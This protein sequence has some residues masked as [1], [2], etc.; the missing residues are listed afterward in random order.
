MKP[1]M[2]IK[3]IRPDPHASANLIGYERKRNVVRDSLENKSSAERSVQWK[4]RII[5]SIVSG[6]LKGLA[7]CIFDIQ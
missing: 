1:E 2:M 7:R 4:R 5:A 6:I 3:D